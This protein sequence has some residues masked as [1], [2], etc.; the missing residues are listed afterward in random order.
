MTRELA[1]PFLRC[2]SAFTTEYVRAV[3]I[4]TPHHYVAH[5]YF[6]PGSPRMI[7]SLA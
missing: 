4:L 2:Y 5:V 1:P 7:L 6:F 3:A